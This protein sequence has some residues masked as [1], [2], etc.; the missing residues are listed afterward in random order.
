[1]TDGSDSNEIRNNRANRNASSGFEVYQS[2]RNKFEKNAA[3]KNGN[4]GFLVFGGA[5][6]NTLIGNSGHGSGLFDGYDEDTGIGDVWKNNHFG[7]TAG[8]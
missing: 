5:S 6:F 8:F 4:Y 3:D 1:M 7:K 2:N